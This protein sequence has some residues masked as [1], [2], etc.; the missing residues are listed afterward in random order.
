[1]I[2]NQ[3]KNPIEQEIVELTSYIFHKYYCENDVDAL[4]QLMDEEI[5]W[6]GAAEHEFDITKEN[7]SA[8]FRSFAGQ[9]PECIISDE[10]YE[11]IALSEK[12]YMCSGRMWISTA[13]STGISLR[14]HQRLTVVFRWKEEGWRCCHIHISN[15][16]AEM[17]EEDVGFPAKMAKQSYEYLLKQI[18]EQE[19]R[20]AAQN[21]LLRRMSYEDAL[22]GLYNR[23]KFIQL[24][25]EPFVH[26][27]V[28][29]GVAC[30][31]LNGLK[32]I[33]DRKGHSTGDELLREAAEEIRGLFSGKAYRIGGDE[34]V[35]IDDSRE[36]K[37]FMEKVH[38]VQMG[39]KKKGIDCAV[40]CSWRRE[41][42]N[43]R[44]QFDEADERMY[45]EK[46]RFYSMKINDR[47][48][49]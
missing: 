11:I 39:M 19:E 33:N 6:I 7:V 13:P 46:R 17:H 20:L 5:V 14:V 36:E 27:E 41:Q 16:Y 31:D 15:P 42:T 29:L 10:E 1:M 40:G 26:P 21:S 4:I 8:I 18:E 24:L 38:A 48:N 45:Q 25:D 34:F 22:T 30:F 3:K 28:G 2:I 43:V 35:I 12:A 32:T 49:N 44:E 23:N 47:R 9:V 37:D